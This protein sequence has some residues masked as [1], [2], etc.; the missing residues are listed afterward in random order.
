MFNA[1][2]TTIIAAAFITGAAHASVTPQLRFG[3]ATASANADREV[4][5]GAGTKWVNVN[6]G[7]TVTFNVSGKSF[8]Y[9]FDTLH[10]E[11][12]FDLAKIAPAGVDTGTVTVYVASN[13]LYRG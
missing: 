1:L 8:T 11:A 3:M 6:N 2:R 10:A 7:D 13:P 5:I 4:T 9:H 12:S